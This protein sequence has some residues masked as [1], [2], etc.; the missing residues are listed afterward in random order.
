VY[1]LVLERNFVNTIIVSVCGVRMGIVSEIFEILK[2]CGSNKT[3]F[4]VFPMDN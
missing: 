2:I 4:S 3:S 1:S